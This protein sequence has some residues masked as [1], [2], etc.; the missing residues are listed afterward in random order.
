V[1]QSLPDNVHVRRLDL[2]ERDSIAAFVNAWDGRLDILVNNAGIMAL[3]TRQVTDEGGELQFATNH[4][5][6]FALA[7]PL[8]TRRQP[9]CRGRSYANSQCRKPFGIRDDRHPVRFVR[10]STSTEPW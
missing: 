8:V 4:L 3:P 7:D 1:F 6:H 9:G 2:V 5:G 10:S